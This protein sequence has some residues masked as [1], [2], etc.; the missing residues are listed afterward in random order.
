MY[1]YR[2]DDRDSFLTAAVSSGH[3][4]LIPAEE[5]GGEDQI[6]LHS[7][8]KDWAIDEIGP[9]VITPGVYDEEGVEIT[10]PVIDNGHHINFRGVPAIEWDGAYIVVNSP[11][12]IFAGAPGPSEVI[13]RLQ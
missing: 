6:L 8:T 5:E 12:R 4:L 7:Y 10:P 3:A 2:F 1:C 11:N 9:L 13:D